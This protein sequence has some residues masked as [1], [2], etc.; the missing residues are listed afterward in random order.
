MSILTIENLD[1][2]NYQL[3]LFNLEKFTHPQ[4]FKVTFDGP[5]VLDKPSPQTVNQLLDFKIDKQ[6]LAK[7]ILAS[8]KYPNIDLV[9]LK[10]SDTKISVLVKNNPHLEKSLNFLSQVNRLNISFGQKNLS[11]TILEYLKRNIDIHIF[12]GSKN[13][14]DLQLARFFYFIKFKTT[15]EPLGLFL[16]GSENLAQVLPPLIYI[17]TKKIYKRNR[18]NFKEE[19]QATW[20]HEL[21]HF[22]DYATANIQH[23][24]DS[25]IENRAEQSEKEL[26]F[27]L[28]DGTLKL[29]LKRN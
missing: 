8:A 3:P 29:V 13:K 6:M 10:T 23:L 20:I 4:H 21:Q 26:R 2:D 18:S 17:N 12:R 28:E 9:P 14:I 1:R 5:Q 27:P 7:S 16:I 11:E 24:S 25:E 15:K 22:F 19:L